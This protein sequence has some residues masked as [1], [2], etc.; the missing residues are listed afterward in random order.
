MVLILLYEVGLAAVSHA[1]TWKGSYLA[2]FVSKTQ[3]GMP[4]LIDKWQVFFFA[5][6]HSKKLIKKINL[7]IDVYLWVYMH[8]DPKFWSTDP[9]FAESSN[10]NSVPGPGPGT[11]S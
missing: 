9:K 1:S 3:N 6:R 4:F 2:R 11:E 5:I 10:M 8:R 7:T